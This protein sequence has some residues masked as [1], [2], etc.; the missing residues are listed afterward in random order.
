MKRR[1]GLVLALS[2]AGVIGC[3]SSPAD[4]EE[5]ILVL[6]IAADRVQCVGEAVGMC[7]QVRSPGESDWRI[8]H[9]PIEG[10]EHEDGVQYRVEV[11]RR[12][13][14]DPPADGSSFAYRLVR[15]I[16]RSSG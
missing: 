3:A 11:A 1:V 9:S 15:V 8:F 6:E 12:E 13:I 2:A 7:I 4:A 14:R 16:S 5:E 10:F